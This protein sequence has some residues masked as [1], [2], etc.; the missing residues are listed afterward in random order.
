MTW[1]TPVNRSKEYVEKIQ[2]TLG[3]DRV[4]LNKRVVSVSRTVDATTGKVTVYVT[5]STGVT[6]T[7]DAI[8]FACH[9]DQALAIL[10]KDA[11]AEERNRLSSFKYSVNDTYVHSDLNLMPRS[12]TAWTCW[13]YMSVSNNQMPVDSHQPVY[14]S[15]WLNKL[16]H[17]KHPRNIFV[18]L[19][20]TYPPA[21]DKTFARIAYSHPQYTAE[22]V[23]AQR[24]VAQKQGH[25]GT[26]FCG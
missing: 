7:C 16:Q 18:S 17:L 20:P 21:V 2:A 25:K 23:K 6:E 9:P 12:K 8:I 3:P 24:L 10:D 22:S 5:D 1:K 19:N 13:N 26:F 4:K 11:D 15:Y 14:V